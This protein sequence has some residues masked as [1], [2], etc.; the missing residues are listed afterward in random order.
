MTTEPEESPFSA[1]TDGVTVAVRL[2]P[3]ASRAGI[4]GV[5]QDADGK[6]LLKVRVTAPPVDGAA[7]AALVKLL[8]KAWRVPARSI[9]ITAGE[10]DRRKVIHVAGDAH[11]LM[12]AILATAGGSTA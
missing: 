2:M 6:A 11:S 12:Q 7:N 3:K 8:A 5:T 4:E 9:T 10:K 1:V